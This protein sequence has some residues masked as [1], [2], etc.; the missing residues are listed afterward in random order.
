MHSI[1][2]LGGTSSNAGRNSA[3]SFRNEKMHQTSRKHLKND[4]FT[5]DKSLVNKSGAAGGAP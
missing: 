2:D 3:S 5:S 4:K 1:K